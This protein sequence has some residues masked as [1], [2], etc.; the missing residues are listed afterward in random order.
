[1]TSISNIKTSTGNMKS[2]NKFCKELLGLCFTSPDECRD[3][4][5]HAFSFDHD[6]LNNMINNNVNNDEKNFYSIKNIKLFQY[7][8]FIPTE[9]IDQ[10]FSKKN[11]TGLFLQLNSEI[12][13][14][15]KYDEDEL[16]T[17]YGYNY[18][19]NNLCEQVL[20]STNIITDKMKYDGISSVPIIIDTFYEES[21]LNA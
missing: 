5:F 4:Y 16:K 1:M 7:V 8:S 20:L 21:I 6:I 2:S 19:K 11:V 3:Q 10:I 12:N 18:L 9:R 15:Y 14:N 13:K 17:I